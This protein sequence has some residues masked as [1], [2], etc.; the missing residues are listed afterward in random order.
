MSFI[1]LIFTFWYFILFIITGLLFVEYSY[2]KE[3]NNNLDQ[4]KQSYQLAFLSLNNLTDNYK[5]LNQEL[6][7]EQQ[8]LIEIKQNLTNKP[9]SSNISKIAKKSI[10]SWP[11]KLNKYW[12]SSVFGP[13]KKSNGKLGF[14]Y[15]IDMAAIKGTAVYAAL[16]GSIDEARYIKGYG[17]TIVILHDKKYLNQKLKTRYA[18]LNKILVKK[19]Q[20]V[21]T[22][23]IIGEVGDT[24]FVRKEGKDASHLHFEVCLNNKRVNPFNFL[25]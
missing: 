17:K 18:H 15:G 9:S 14:H 5:I 2:F 21:K 22:G 24:G 8:K 25:A 12:I 6:K 1:K 16:S 3:Q 7:S 23:Q 13:R 10:L 20:K 19:N 4:I 11:I